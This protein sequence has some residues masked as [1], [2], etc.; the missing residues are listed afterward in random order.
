MKKI[1]LIIVVLT[2]ILTNIM[3]LQAQKEKMDVLQGNAVFLE[4]AVGNVVLVIDT[5]SDM[6]GVSWRLE[7]PPSIKI[8]KYEYF[9][10]GIP[11]GGWEREVDDTLSTANFNVIHPKGNARYGWYRLHHFGKSNVSF[12]TT[13]GI[14]IRFVMRV[15]DS[16][17][18]L[19]V[20]VKH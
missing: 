17:T 5:A 11:F 19:K 18:R 9:N 14:L 16:G 15:N 20:W 3:T 2:I 1:K 4:T 13:T 12:Y 10:R 8:K 7:F 6:Y